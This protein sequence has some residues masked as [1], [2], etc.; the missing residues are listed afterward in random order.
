MSMAA[1][2]VGELAAGV[3]VCDDERGAPAAVEVAGA[4]VPGAG[5]VPEV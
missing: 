2:T 4:G 3:D 1:S 5:L